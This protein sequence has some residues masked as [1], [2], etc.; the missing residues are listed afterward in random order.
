MRQLGLLVGAAMDTLQGA[1]EWENSTDEIAIQLVWTE[2]K[3]GLVYL[4]LRTMLRAE[5]WVFHGRLSESGG[6]CTPLQSKTIQNSR[7]L[8]YGQLNGHVASIVSIFKRRFWREVVCLRDTGKEGKYLRD[9]KEWQA[10][11]LCYCKKVCKEKLC[12][13]IKLC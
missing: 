1:G 13:K 6:M 7:V 11:S 10:W 4:M 2:W 5:P 3:S 8:G 12:F 9:T